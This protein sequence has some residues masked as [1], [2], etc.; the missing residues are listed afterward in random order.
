MS[1]RT[2]MF[3]RSERAAA[4]G[5]DWRYQET[6]PALPP[7][8][9]TASTGSER[10]MRQHGCALTSVRRAVSL[11]RLHRY[12][13]RLVGETRED[14]AAGCDK[15]RPM[16]LSIALARLALWSSSQRP[17]AGGDSAGGWR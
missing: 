6:L 1:S 16:P 8:L 10:S 15:D 7:I 13:S 2:H 3:K 4:L 14:P 17:N 5:Q 11:S 9:A 12:P